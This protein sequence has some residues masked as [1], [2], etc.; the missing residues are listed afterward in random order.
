MRSLGF[1][2]VTSI[3]VV[4]GASIGCG[5]SRGIAGTAMIRARPVQCGSGGSGNDSGSP[6]DYVD[7]LIVA[8]D[9]LSA[10]A[11]RYRDFRNAGGHHVD[12]AMVSDLV[13]DAADARRQA[14]GFRPTCCHTT[15]PATPRGR[16]SSFFSET[17]RPSG[18]GRQRRAHRIL[19]RSIDY[20]CGDF[21]QRLRRHEWR[22]CSRDRRGPNHR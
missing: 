2:V 22:R 18:R 4:L 12:L 3:A 6:T 7:Y 20:D 8:A 21:G 15:M 14:P 11:A 13:G 16:C 17:R 10:S 1:I 19:D 5:S 9:G